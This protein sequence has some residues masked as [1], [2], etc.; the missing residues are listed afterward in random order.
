M[1]AI[2]SP[3]KKVDI[4]QALRQHQTTV[5]D[6]R[7]NFVADY[8]EESP[9]YDPGDHLQFLIENRI[10]AFQ[11]DMDIRM[12]TR[13]KEIERIEKRIAELEEELRPLEEKHR[14]AAGN[15]GSAKERL[16]SWNTEVNGLP[17]VESEAEKYGQDV[18]D[19]AKWK[20]LAAV[21]KR[22]RD[23][24]LSKLKSQQST[25]KFTPYPETDNL[26]KLEYPRN[27]ELTKREQ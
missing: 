22:E 10:T 6:R 21:A 15:Y 17:T 19:H 8:V 26:S 24:V 18:A 2:S 7:R 12:F 13:A 5:E 4:H 16:D 14:T 11:L 23:E 27:F 9:D 20:S 1:I 3:E 25:L